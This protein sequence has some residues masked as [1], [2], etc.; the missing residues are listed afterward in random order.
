MKRVMAFLILLGL[1]GLAVGCQQKTTTPGISKI[2]PT[3]QAP[4]K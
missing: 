3:Q 4:K 2:R 1:V